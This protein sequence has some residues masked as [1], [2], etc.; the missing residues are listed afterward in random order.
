MEAQASRA[1]HAADMLGFTLLELLLVVFIMAM[2]AGGAAWSLR[3]SA[4]Q[5]LAREAQRL[6]AMLEGGRAQSRLQG[7]PLYWVA[8]PGGFRFE[9]LV[10]PAESTPS[11]PANARWLNDY[12][13]PLE[14]AGGTRV[15]LGPEAVL[16]AQSVTLARRD[17]PALRMRVHSD[18]MRPFSVQRESP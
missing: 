7:T 2:A 1:S 8:Q 11:I 17:R 12:T 6:A 18:G 13:T 10:V 15:L 4:E 5:D 9:G 3:D 14:P 16:P